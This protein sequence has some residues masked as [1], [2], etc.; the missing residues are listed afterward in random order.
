MISSTFN[1]LPSAGLDIQ[2]SAHDC[3]LSSTNTLVVWSKLARRSGATDRLRGESPRGQTCQPANGLMLEQEMRSCAL[4]CTT[5]P[6]P[7]PLVI[8]LTRAYDSQ[9]QR[10]TQTCTQRPL[11]RQTDRPLRAPEARRKTRPLRSNDTAE[12]RQ[13]VR[14]CHL[15]RH[16]DS[17]PPARPRKP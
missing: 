6:K 2:I 12:V 1:R 17:H 9:N 5:S 14:V 10:C 15:G 7:R 13:N 11:N 4:K 16:C 3:Q 8:A